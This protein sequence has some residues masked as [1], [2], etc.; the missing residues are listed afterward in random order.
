MKKLML[1]ACGLCIAGVSFA[2]QSVLKEAERGMKVEVPDH[3]KIARM[4]EGAMTNP[5][6]A[7]EVKTWYLAGKN[8]F[9]TWQTGWELLQIGQ[10]PDKVNMSRA[11]VNGFDYYT[12][13]LPMDTVVDAKGKV[14]TKYSKEIVK[15]LAASPVN[16]YD[17]GVFLYEAN[18]LKGAYRAWEIYTLIPKMGAQLGK[19][20]PAMPSD[21][22]MATTYYN[23]G[24]FAY[25]AGMKP[26]AM[27]S[28]LE[29]AHLGQGETAYDNALAMAQDLEDMQAME[30]IATEAFKAYGKQN[31]IGALVSIYV[32]NGQYDK[33]R[34]MVD[35]A[36]EANPGN[37]VLFNTKAILIE[38][39]SS[40]E[41]LAPE[42]VK[43]IN[44]EAT[45]YYKKAVDADPEFAE[46]RYHYGR[47]LAN[48]AYNL[49][50]SEEVNNLTTKEYNAF[51]ES[52]IDPLFRQAA[53][54]LEIA[55]KLNP[56]ANR[57]AFTILKNLYYNLGD[58][59]NMKRIEDL[60]LE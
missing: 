30:A 4:L 17:A 2:Q 3:A 14:K 11:I 24:I 26:E 28:F 52:T 31:Y 38:T 48:S 27:K 8:A 58:E 33:A 20:T 55:I 5:E 40:D 43:K 6:T 23:M 35:K 41:S 19:E 1:L 32:K 42:Q 7:N 51:K 44:D 60:E 54:Q 59:E 45:E 10:E 53:E 13:A 15:T 21:S 39:S 12:K 29:A 47:M 34:D 56:E 25:Q 57:Q 50:D 46:A 36:L 18:D 9:Q 22:I 49:N 37:A 16:F